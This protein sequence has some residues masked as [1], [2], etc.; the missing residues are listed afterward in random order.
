MR[1]KWEKILVF[2]K[3][4]QFIVLLFFLFAGQANA[5][6]TESYY[7]GIG[8]NATYAPLAGLN[9]AINHY[10]NVRFVNDPNQSPEGEKTINSISG[11]NILLGPSISMGYMVKPDYN[12]EI[13]FMDRSSNSRTTQVQNTSGDVI[14]R[15]FRVR[16]RSYG[17]GFSRL[18]ATGNQD[19]IIGG[20]I[21]YSRL[22]VEG[23]NLLDNAPINQS[24]FGATAFIKY[25]FNFS[26]TSPFAIVINPFLQYHFVP[27]DFAR[28]NE[29]LNPKTYQSLNS[30]D[31]KG[32]RTYF[33][34]E[35]Q[36]NYFVFTRFNKERIE[37]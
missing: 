8:L 22:S 37:E 21:N 28:F 18:F 35:I 23:T 6:N 20:T 31:L 36:L 4:R 19:Y 24:Q 12:I 27:V 34:L 13:R 30:S 16:S 15:D 14:T 26:E 3:L 29:V 1:Q 32:A 33:G 7:F 9:D 17:F 5:Q 2:S 25:I 11:I 10:Q